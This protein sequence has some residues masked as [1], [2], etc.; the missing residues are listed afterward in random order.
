[1]SVETIKAES[2][3]LRSRLPIE[4]QEPTPNFSDD[5]WQILKFHGMYQQHDRDVRGR[6]NRAYS[7]MIRS[8]LPGGKLTPQQYLVQ[9]A[10]A[11]QFGQGDLRFTTRQGIQLHGVI[12][13]NLQETLRALNGVLVT[14]LGACGDVVR[15]VMSCPAPFGDPVRAQ[16]QATA[17][18]ISQHMA[19]HTTAYHEIWLEGDDGKKSL[20]SFPTGETNGHIN[21]AGNGVAQSAGSAHEPIY[22]K[23]YLPRKFKIALAFPGDNCT[24][25]MTNDIGLVGLFEGDTLYGFNVFAGGG[26]GSTHNNADTFPLLAKPMGYVPAEQVVDVVEKI[27]MVQRDFGD[28]EDRKHARMKY[29]I[30]E[31]GMDKFRAKVEEYL[32]Y[33]VEPLRPM[34][35][36]QADDHLGWQQQTD[37][38]WF[39]GIYVE[40]GRLRDNGDQRPRS[41]VRALVQR[42]QPGVYITPQQN[43]LLSGFTTAQKAEV[44]QLLADF[45]VATVEQL[46]NVRRHSLACPA[47][48]TCGLALAEAERF[49]PT[50]VDQ[51]EPIVAELG[52]DK[53][54]FTMRMTGCPN[55]CARPYVADIGL[56]GRSLGKYTLFLGGN[57]EGTRLNTQY[58]DLIPADDV[59]TVIRQVLLAYR[60]TRHEGERVGDWANRVGVDLIHELSDSLVVA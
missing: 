40:N 4:L 9:D 23:T 32:G 30:H 42:Y 2:N 52:L 19:P 16:L 17:E 56:V 22:G 26:L 50:V 14:T 33:S 6:N 46:T 7:F 12:K 8:K 1:M 18:A 21:G 29:L 43:V 35:D 39:Y 20:Q 51:L 24:D 48:P 15:N 44:E 38:N 37:G 5:V 47:L 60:Q 31:W 55:G 58:Q 41:A 53:E 25:I 27:V 36:L 49:L 34:P 54:L 28:R 59:P 57:P 11:D 10:L 45:G 3:G 13:G